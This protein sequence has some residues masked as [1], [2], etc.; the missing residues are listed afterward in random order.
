MAMIMSLPVILS[1]AY[2]IYFLIGM[3]ETIFRLW[4]Y[5]DLI[6]VPIFSCYFLIAKKQYLRK[7]RHDRK[8]FEQEK[9]KQKIQRDEIVRQRS[10]TL[11]KIVL[12]NDYV[13]TV[14]NSVIGPE[15]K[16]SFLSINQDQKSN[17]F[18][19]SVGAGYQRISKEIMEMA[20][21]MQY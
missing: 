19:F 20:S 11:K 4:L 6:V 3:T 18:Q 13:P 10:L 15:A 2:Q 7:Q 1:Y 12:T 21:D 14:S 5:I 17:E 9:F 16:E 8:K